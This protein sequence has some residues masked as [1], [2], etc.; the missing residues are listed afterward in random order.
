[1]VKIINATEAKNHFGELIQQV[2]LHGQHL[3]VKKDKIPVVAIVPI[4]DYEHLLPY[5]TTPPEIIRDI[6]Q[7]AKQ[8][9]AAKR[10]N[11]FLNKLH[12]KMPDTS[13]RKA[14]RDINKAIDGI[15]KAK[16]KQ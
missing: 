7:G 5:N 4:A 16:K 14:N 1:M 3:I 9:A 6:K 13:E 11:E 8:E 2:Y 15:R 10:L 12:K